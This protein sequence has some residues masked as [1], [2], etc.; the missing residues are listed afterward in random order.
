MV[1]NKTQSLTITAI[2]TGL[3][4]LQLFVPNVGYLYILPGLPA[5]TTIPLTV[6][7]YGVLMGPKAGGF[8]GLTWGIL[9]LIVAYTQPADP[10]SLLLFQ[11]P[12]IA[13]L[14]RYFAGLFAGVA[15]PKHAQGT[16]W[17]SALGGLLAS[18]LNTLLVIVFASLIFMHNPTALTSHLGHI[19]QNNPL[20]LILLLA[21]GV[22]GISEAIFTALVTPLITVPLLKYARAH[23]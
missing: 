12:L 1:R 5:I 9:S 8:F 13:I 4:L 18:A 3:L 21:L 22:N 23:F 16:A 7:V 11:N 20:I 2:F 19:N 10:A 17:H 6:A 15:Q 14:P